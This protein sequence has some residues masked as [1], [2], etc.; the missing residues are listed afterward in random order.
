MAGA[1]ACAKACLTMP[2]AEVALEVRSSLVVLRATPRNP[3]TL[4]TGADEQTW[5]RWAGVP[6]VH[7]V[8]TRY[9]TYLH[10]SATDSLAEAEAERLLRAYVL[11]SSN[12][13]ARLCI[14]YVRAG[15]KPPP[16]RE[17]D[18]PLGPHAQSSKHFCEGVR[19][20]LPPTGR[21]PH[22]P[23]APTVMCPG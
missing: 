18:R 15:L 13:A 22:S 7:A 14:D 23:R 20:Y 5:S 4:A 1:D 12:A 6:T 17:H 2:P 9:F 21:P 10:S 11:R 19:T 3:A 16:G 8:N